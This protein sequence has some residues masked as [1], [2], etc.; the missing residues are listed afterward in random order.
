VQGLY[1]KKLHDAEVKEQYQVSTSNRFSAL[2]NLDGNVDITKA[3]ENTRENITLSAKACLGHYDLKQ[4]KPWFEE[5]IS[6]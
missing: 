5:E 2:E 6:H 4:Y 1:L 3:C